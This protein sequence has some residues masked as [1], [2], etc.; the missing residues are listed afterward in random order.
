MKRN[1]IETNMKFIIQFSALWQL[2]EQTTLYRLDLSLPVV[3]WYHWYMVHGRVS[4]GGLGNKWEKFW[5]LAI[6]Y[7]IKLL[8]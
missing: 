3:V 1:D 2:V 6:G 4:S 7:S 5:L 8:K